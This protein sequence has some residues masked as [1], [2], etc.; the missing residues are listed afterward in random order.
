MKHCCSVLLLA[1][2]I[3]GTV[4]GRNAPD[5][6]LS[7]STGKRIS[8]SNYR[9]K[10]VVIEFIAITCPHCREASKALEKLKADAGKRFEVLG[11]SIEGADQRTLAEYKRVF[12]IS[13][14][15]LQASPKVVT[16]YLGSSSGHVPVFFVVSPSGQIIQERNPDHASDRDFYNRPGAKANESDD[17][18]MAGNL[19]AMI[20]QAIPKRAA[21][22]PPGIRKAP[23]AEKE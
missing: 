11:I 5:F 16:D 13:Y 20:R 12:G 18:W 10:Y 17:D 7:D 3:G 19:E 23:A 21:K 6:T 1:L 14:P 2:A 15:L 9:G 4:R 8:L 22:A